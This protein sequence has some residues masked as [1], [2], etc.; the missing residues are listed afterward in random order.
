VR[1][2]RR[3][4]FLA[5]A[6]VATRADAMPVLRIGAAF[7]PQLV[8]IQQAALL[9]RP[10]GLQID[11]APGEPA[12]LF[13]ALRAG[14]LAASASHTAQQLDGTGATAAFDT[15]TL[16]TGIYSHRVKSI[17]QLRDGD[18]V[19]MPAAPLEHARAQVLLYNYRLLFAHEDDGLTQDLSTIVN[20]RH[21]RFV[22]A[23][24][25]LLA[26]RLDDTAAAVLPYADAVAAGLLPGTDSIGLEDGNSPYTQVLAVREADRGAP[27]LAAL[28][29]V[30]QSREMRRF[31]Y[32]RYGE[33]VRP[34]W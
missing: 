23:S 17:V 26:R 6:L 7:G 12:A 11:V 25:S 24:P 3:R 5:G 18:A 27:W 1:L 33:S 31:I 14:T 21:F 34:P 8:L 32:T 2:I 13:A 15:V 20:P 29:R 4:H 19:A 9:S 16:P 30:F 22:A 10:H 28:A